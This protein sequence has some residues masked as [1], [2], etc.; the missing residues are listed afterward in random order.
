MDTDIHLDT[1][2][3]PVCDCAILPKRFTIPVD[4]LQTGS[5][6][7]IKTSQTTRTKNG[8]IKARAGGLVQGTGR[9]RPALNRAA[10]TRGK[11]ASQQQQQLIEEP[12]PAVRTKTV[13]DQAQTPLYCSEECR[14]RDL[15]E[16]WPVTPAPAR[17]VLDGHRRSS[18]IRLGAHPAQINPAR[19]SPPPPSPTLPPVPPNSWRAPMGLKARDLELNFDELAASIQEADEH[20]D[21]SSATGTSFTTSDRSPVEERDSID[22]SNL[23]TDPPPP[24]LAP[25]PL[26]PH[27]PSA[28]VVPPGA[29]RT[30][31]HPLFEGGIMMAAKRLQ[32]LL[33]SDVSDDEKTRAERRAAEEQQRKVEARLSRYD[34]TGEYA[35]SSSSERDKKRQEVPAIDPMRWT[36]LVYN[37]RS[38]SSSP[39]SNPGIP[40]THRRASDSDPSKRIRSP[41]APSRTQSALELYAKYPLFARSTSNTAPRKTNKSSASLATTFAPAYGV[42]LSSS[43][44]ITS[45]TSSVS[46]RTAGA[47]ALTIPGV[48]PELYAGKRLGGGPRRPIAKG[49]EKQ[50]LVPDVL[51]RPTLPVS[52][53]L[54]TGMSPPSRLS[55]EMKRSGSEANV[56]RK[57]GRSASVLGSVNEG[58]VEGVQ[59]VWHRPEE[60]SEDSRSS[61]TRSSTSD[62]E[63][64]SRRGKKSRSSKSGSRQ[65]IAEE[66]S[67]SYENSGPVYD[68]MPAIP[69]KQT[70]YEEA[71]VPD[72][73]SPEGEEEYIERSALH[74]RDIELSRRAVCEV[75]RRRGER[76]GKAGWWVEKEWEVTVI[77]ERKRLF[78]FGGSKGNGKRN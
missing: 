33:A 76:N 64:R 43:T 13:I 29:N 8:T 40:S 63:S 65:P 71:F 37:Y 7:A 3:C 1:S 35:R 31:S 38:G 9:V 67:W 32:A 39:P 14:K 17:D 23:Y 36:E 34:V 41:G 11:T 52:S 47:S 20:S 42:T 73:P 51:L 12:T 28:P 18:R 53:S 70:R 56:S 44:S 75:K 58:D 59:G 46:G 48:D 72:E 57:S 68:A 55:S 19:A 10:S 49:V 61:V 77:P 30:Q 25:L 5:S 6:T 27:R 62:Q 74:A 50:L 16:S 24:P 4:L 60:G 22:T 26:H 54:P 15:E 69:V 78:L 45:S 66:S 21:S 2:W